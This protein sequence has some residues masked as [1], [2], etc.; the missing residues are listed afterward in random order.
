MER[1]GE[2][3]GVWAGGLL[4]A[5]CQEV[6]AV[7]KLQAEDREDEQQRYAVRADD[8]PRAD[9]QAVDEPEEHARRQCGIGAERD[10]VRAALAQDF[11][12][13]W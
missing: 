11:Y 6:S 4:T 7:A 1:A 3:F 8:R 2:C 5:G 13:L 10:V 12:D 9:E